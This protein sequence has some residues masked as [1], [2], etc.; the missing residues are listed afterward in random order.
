MFSYS[1]LQASFRSYLSLAA[2]LS[3]GLSAAQQGFAQEP[4]T[5]EVADDWVAATM[6]AADNRAVDLNQATN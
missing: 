1:R 4:A 2:L 6:C 5:E 3:L